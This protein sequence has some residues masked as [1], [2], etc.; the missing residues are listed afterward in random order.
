MQSTTRVSNANMMSFRE[1]LSRFSWSLF[2]PMC[3]VLL[4]SLVVLFSAGGGSWFPF[5]MSQL[6]KV[7]FC[8]GIFFVISFSNIKFWIKSAYIWYIIALI[9]IVWQI[10]S[11]LG[12]VDS[13]MLPSPLKVGKAFVEE[14][15]TLMEH[16]AITLSEAFIGLGL[17]ILLGFI[18]IFL[19]IFIA[20]YLSVILFLAGLPTLFTGNLTD[21]IF[22]LGVPVG[23]FLF[24]TYSKEINKRM[25][26]EERKLT[27]LNKIMV[28]LS[29][30]VQVFLYIGD[31]MGTELNAATVMDSDEKMLKEICKQQK[32]TLPRN[33]NEEF[34]WAD[35]TLNGDV[36]VDYTD[37]TLNELM[38]IE[39]DEKVISEKD[40]LKL[41][42]FFTDSL[43]P[44]EP[45]ITKTIFE[46]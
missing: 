8:M 26:K 15:P 34:Y 20:K 38:D 46:L 2:I 4:L 1:K 32:E 30:I 27:K 39:Y 9:L 14:F 5:A 29:I 3:V 44:L 33:L 22:N 36:V 13:F 6:L 18:I 25:P 19:P 16:S 40:N 28:I 35:I 42:L 41:L 21:I 45:P 31:F 11:M 24:L 37:A 12:I 7:I 17:G 10:I 23:F 43:N